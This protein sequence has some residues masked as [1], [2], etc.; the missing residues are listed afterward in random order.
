MSCTK[1]RTRY[2]RSLA[3]VCK[4][5]FSQKPHDFLRRFTRNEISKK[6]FS[7][8]LQKI[9]LSLLQYQHGKKHSKLRFKFCKTTQFPTLKVHNKTSLFSY[10]YP[11]S[12][13]CVATENLRLSVKQGL[14]NYRKHI[15]MVTVRQH[16]QSHL[17]T[18]VSQ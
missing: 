2:S 17:F 3:R 8:G 12:H 13:Y 18:S 9:L 11:V 4:H 16:F 10:S 6:Y 5:P 7:R 15:Q 1:R 14:I